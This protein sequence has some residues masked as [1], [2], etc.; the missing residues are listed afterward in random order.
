[1]WGRNPVTIIYW[2]KRLCQFW[3]YFSLFVIIFLLLL[4]MLV[5]FNTIESFCKSADSH[6]YLMV[7]TF[8][9]KLYSR[10]D[11]HYQLFGMFA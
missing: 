8:N 7:H 11:D 10:S 2:R 6:I 1:M 4:V 9:M 3:L 5:C